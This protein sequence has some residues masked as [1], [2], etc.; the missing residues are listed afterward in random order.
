[1]ATSELL[2]A[3][4]EC[5]D[6]DVTRL[7]SDLDNYVIICQSTTRK[8]RDYA[9]NRTVSIY[10]YGNVLIHK[11]TG[12]KHVVTEDEFTDEFDMYDFVCISPHKDG[13]YSYVCGDMNCKC[14][15][16]RK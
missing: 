9:M 10:L 7:S 5:N 4:D 3:L 15:K 8:L 2:E 6:G 16:K 1:M 13:D 11:V 12:A 14:H